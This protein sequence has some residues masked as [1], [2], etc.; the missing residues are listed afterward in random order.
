MTLC[1]IDHILFIDIISMIYMGKLKQFAEAI[2]FLCVDTNTFMLRNCCYYELSL[3][4]DHY[5]S[6]CFIELFMKVCTCV[7]AYAYSLLICL[8]TIDY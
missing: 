4:L 5:I 7:I 1:L 8:Q 2:I 6:K 3:I